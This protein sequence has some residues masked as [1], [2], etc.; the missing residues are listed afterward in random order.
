[1]EPTRS[2]PVRST[3][4]GQLFDGRHF[5]LWEGVPPGREVVYFV[6]TPGCGPGCRLRVAP[7]DGMTTAPPT[8]IDLDGKAEPSPPDWPSATGGLDLSRVPR[9]LGRLVGASESGPT[10][11]CLAGLHGNEPA[12]LEAFLR[13]Q[14]R[15][16]SNPAGLE[17]HLIGLT[18]NRMALAKNKRYL[19]HDLNR[20]WHLDRIAATRST[21]VPVEAEDQELRELDYALQSVLDEAQGRVYLLDLHT[22]SGPGGAFAILDDTLPNREIA[23][24][25]PVP[26]VLG[27]E[28]ELGGTLAA[29]STALGITVVGFEAGQHDDPLAVDRAAAA[30]WVF[31]ESCGVL[32]EE[33][34]PEVE[35][36]RRLLA[37]SNGVRSRIVEVRHRHH[38][39]EQDGF[40]MK[41]G[42]AGFHRVA[43]G[44]VLAFSSSGPIK[45]PQAGLL[46]MPLYQDQ[47][48]DGFFL[49]REIQPVWLSVSKALRGL[50]VEKL[51]HLLPGVR[52]HPELS[53]SFIVDRRYA[54]WLA[55]QLFHLLGFRR[56]GR[57][58]RTLIMSRRRDQAS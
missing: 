26:L 45:A 31:M 57:A 18:G 19:V 10:L 33:S 21:P 47:G 16:A 51:L 29:Y 54:R 53:G 44:E 55:R 46:L 37:A 35:Q 8:E 13:V 28:E 12:G 6:A 49:V 30:I 17:G 2:D 23:L 24:D 50:G 27:L 14:D 11:I 7:A 52:R 40:E 9:E 22:T 5:L 3:A 42:L 34:W 1:V 36:A 58:G 48:E 41:P 38:I 32:H 43:E 15:L 56:V 20:I 25:F 4:D 39:E